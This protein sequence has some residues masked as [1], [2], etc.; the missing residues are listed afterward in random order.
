M[1]ADQVIG[2]RLG[3][4]HG[5]V[6]ADLVTQ[7]EGA[8]EPFPPNRLACL[9]AAIEALKAAF[10]GV[11]AKYVAEFQGERPLICTCFGVTEDT[12]ETCIARNHLISVDEVAERCKAGGGC[13]SCRML[14]QELID[15]AGNGGA[16]ASE[17]DLR[18]P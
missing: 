9:T 17:C 6:P 5:L 7:V 3:D 8:V 1:L 10:A 16:A 4:L 11:R 15:I 18:L 2:R 13:G 14:I 12:I